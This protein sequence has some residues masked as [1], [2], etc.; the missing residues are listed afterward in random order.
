MMLEERSDWIQL[1]QNQVDIQQAAEQ[2]EV[3]MDIF[4]GLVFEVALQLTAQ[5]IVVAL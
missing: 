2:L 3:L 5:A 4:S 1:I